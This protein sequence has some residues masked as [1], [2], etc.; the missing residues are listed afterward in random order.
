M[1]TDIIRCLQKFFP[2]YDFYIPWNFFSFWTWHIRDDSHIQPQRCL[3]CYLF[4]NLS[5]TDDPE[6]LSCYI[7]PFQ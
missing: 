5:K 1:Q 6:C 4:S 7:G 2:G 3:S